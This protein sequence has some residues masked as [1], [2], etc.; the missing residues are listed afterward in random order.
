[1]PSKAGTCWVSHCF[2]NVQVLLFIARIFGWIQFGPLDPIFWQELMY[3]FW[4]MHSVFWQSS[5]LLTNFLKTYSRLNDAE[6][7][8]LNARFCFHLPPNISLLTKQPINLKFLVF[9]IVILLLSAIGKT[10]EQN[11]Q[12]SIVR[13]YPRLQFCVEKSLKTDFQD[14]IH[15]NKQWR[16]GIKNAISFALQPKKGAG[17]WREVL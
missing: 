16:I 5:A 15:T 4:H 6:H 13:M 17:E 10:E 14:L 3:C 11:R 9:I 8:F 1:M 2:Q 7:F 12:W